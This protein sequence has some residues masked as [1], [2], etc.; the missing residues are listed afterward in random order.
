[1]SEVIYEV[2]LAV[3]QD[4]A[5]AFGQWLEAHIEEMVRLP[6]FIDATWHQLEGTPA[7]VKWSIHYRLVSLEAYERYITQDAPKMRGDGL[8]RFGGQFEATRRLLSVHKIF[9]P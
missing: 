4:I 6:G 2:N 3:E 7:A 1:M 9:S 8:T 5:E